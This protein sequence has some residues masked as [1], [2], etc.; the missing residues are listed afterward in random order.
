MGALLGNPWVV[1]AIVAGLVASHGAV[2]LRGRDDGGNA[3]V[4]TQYREERASAKAA[5]ASA[6]AAAVAISQITVKHQTVRQELQREIIEKP[7]YRDPDCRTGAD[8]LQRF[9]SAIPGAK[10]GADRGELPASDPG[11]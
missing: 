5:E 8:S 2:Y 10:P 9:N 3:E 11:H 6:S 7:V 4:A 1:L